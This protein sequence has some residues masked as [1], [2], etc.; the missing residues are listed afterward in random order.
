MRSNI[1]ASP[2]PGPGGRIGLLL[3]QI[4]LGTLCTLSVCVLLQFYIWG[5]PAFTL[6]KYVICPG[7]VMIHQQYYRLLS[8][9]FFHSGALHIL[10]NMMSL[11]YLGKT[12]ESKLGT[13]VFI[14]LTIQFALLSNTL[15]VL[16]AYA[17][18]Y[19]T[20][21]MSWNNYCSVGFSGVLFAFLVIQTRIS[22]AQTRSI[23]GVISVPTFIYPWVLLLLLQILMPNISFLGHL[24][25]L[26]MGIFYTRGYLQL[27]SLPTWILQKIEN[28][29]L[30]KIPLFVT[31][32]PERC[33]SFPSDPLSTL[34]GCSFTVR[35][36]QAS[37]RFP[38]TGHVLGRS[39]YDRLGQEDPTA[40]SITDIEDSE[41]KSAVEMSLG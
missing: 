40:P 10:M 16:T 6:N 14:G 1:N 35:I 19:L 21:D 25:G 36:P 39:P 8:S 33:F 9:A 13:L 26:L 24:A 15:Y 11:F 34:C 32:S 12:I 30:E 28:S 7:S 18:A 3:A 23:F 17:M 20:A 37:N 5:S 31:C 29:G 22:D 4:P 2:D 41:L 27:L 38:G